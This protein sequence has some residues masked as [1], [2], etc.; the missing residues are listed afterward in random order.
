MRSLQILRSYV[1]AGSGEAFDLWLASARDG[2]PDWTHFGMLFTGPL[3][4][5]EGGSL[6]YPASHFPK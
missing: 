5:T 6:T 2:A 3:R 1:A 4:H